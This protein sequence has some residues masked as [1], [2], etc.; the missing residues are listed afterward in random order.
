MCTTVN[1][2][3]RPPPWRP[4][5]RTAIICFLVAIAILVGVLILVAFSPR[6]DGSDDAA[7]DGAAAAPVSTSIE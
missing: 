5:P 2:P 7:A 4:R 6:D 3:Y 1:K